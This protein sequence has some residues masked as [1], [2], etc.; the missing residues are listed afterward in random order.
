MAIGYH[1][2]QRFVEVVGGPFNANSEMGLVLQS[3]FVYANV[4]VYN[5]NLQ[6]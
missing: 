1:V 2:E 6:S 5:S 3:I 4:C